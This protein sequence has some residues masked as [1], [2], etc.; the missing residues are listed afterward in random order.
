[1]RLITHS[2]NSCQSI[3]L[4]FSLSIGGNLD[5]TLGSNVVSFIVSLLGKPATSGLSGFILSDLTTLPP[6][7]GSIAGVISY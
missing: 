7:S 6:N 1:M 3:P 2:Y 5:A 4:N